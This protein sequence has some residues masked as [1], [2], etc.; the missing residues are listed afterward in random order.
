MTRLF[1]ERTERFDNLST[2]FS[3]SATSHRL[4]VW[5]HSQIGSSLHWLW[6][7][8]KLP[9]NLNWSIFCDLS[10]MTFALMTT[11]RPTFA[12]RTPRPSNARNPSR[13]SARRSLIVRAD[14]VSLFQANSSHLHVVWNNVVFIRECHWRGCCLWFNASIWP[15]KVVSLPEHGNQKIRSETPSHSA[16]ALLLRRILK[17][18][19]GFMT[20]FSSSLRAT[21]PMWI[22]LNIF[23]SS[24]KYLTTVGL[25]CLQ[26]RIKRCQA[27]M[28]MLQDPQ[29]AAKDAGKD[30]SEGLEGAI[31]KGKDALK[32]LSGKAD[33]AAG[34][35]KGYVSSNAWYHCRTK[36]G[37]K[38]SLSLK[39]LFL[40]WDELV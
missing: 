11:S 4:P 21:H 25:T 6:F 27:W 35:A 38:M 37:S 18:W 15:S 28:T 22:S 5:S 10:S 17:D 31:N 7:R 39:Q 26:M 32:D 40:G 30:V 12:V 19:R 20:K 8:R 16:K 9:K 33:D 2:L 24:W 1:G 13:V 23:C 3:D 29:Q 14:K 36:S 34:D